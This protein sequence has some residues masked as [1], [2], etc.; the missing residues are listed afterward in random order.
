ME[1]SEAVLR[2]HNHA[3]M[4]GT[5]LAESESFLFALW[6]AE[7]QPDIPELR[8]LFEDLLD[9]LVVVNH[10][11]NTEHPSGTIAGKLETLPRPLVADISAILSVGWSDY[12]RWSSNQQFTEAFRAE[13]AAKLVQIGIA[14]D[15]VLAG[16]IDDIRNHVQTEFNAAV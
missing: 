3:N 8:R 16:D 12:W 13:F 10:A 15:A 4:P 5:S 2:L 6:Q 14:W 11:V 1:Y 9:C 7:R